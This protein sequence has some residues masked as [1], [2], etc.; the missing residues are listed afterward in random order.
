MSAV[1][2]LS[3]PVFVACIVSACGNSATH[4][5]A[6][7]RS[8]ETTTTARP[9]AQAV[10]QWR[11][12]AT[13]DANAIS[14]SMERITDSLTRNQPDFDAVKAA[15]REFK[16]NTEDLSAHLPSPDPKLTAVVEAAVTSYIEAAKTCLDATPDVQDPAWEQVVTKVEEGARHMAEAGDIMNA[17][18]R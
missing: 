9:I 13:P 16:H 4:E 12:E 7:A 1:A 2:K 8:G 11:H 6:S 15:C 5:V 14:G 17:Y 18:S 3:L 10:A